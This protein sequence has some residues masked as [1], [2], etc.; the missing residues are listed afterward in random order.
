MCFTCSD[1]SREWEAKFEAALDRCG[2]KLEGEAKEVYKQMLEAERT[3]GDRMAAKEKERRA[4]NP[5]SP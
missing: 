1:E 5:F 3:Y 2:G 4:Q